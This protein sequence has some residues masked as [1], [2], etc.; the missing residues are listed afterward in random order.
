MVVHTSTVTKPKTIL[1]AME[2]MDREI[3]KK[4]LK[5]IILCNYDPGKWPDVT[6]C[7]NVRNL[8]VKCD[9]PKYSHF[10][11][12]QLKTENNFYFYIFNVYLYLCLCVLYLYIFFIARILILQ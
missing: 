12:P 1:W 11:F 2:I 10:E 3:V 5:L 7:D 8:F 6:I 9:S 4:K